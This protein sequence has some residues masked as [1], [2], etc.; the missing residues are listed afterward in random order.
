MLSAC[1]Y[2]ILQT[3][4]A[5]L[6]LR[7]D[8]VLY[9][10]G[11]E[12]FDVTTPLGAEAVQIKTS[13]SPISLGQKSIQ[14]TI[15]QFWALKSASGKRLVRMKF[16]TRAPFTVERGNPFGHNVAGLELWQRPINEEEVSKIRDFLLSQAHIESTLQ[17]W[18]QAAT[19]TQIR[20]ELLE[21][22]TWE[23][24]APDTQ[25]VERSILCKLAAFSDR[26]GS[27]GASM[28]RQ[29][30]NRLCVEVCR[31]LRN[32]APRALDSF[33]LEEIWEEETCVPIPRTALIARMSS[34]PAQGFQPME[35][36]RLLRKGIPPLPGVV[37]TRKNLVESWRG[38]LSRTG[39]LNLHGSTRTGKTTLAKLAA[40]PD[41]NSWNWW[42]A[43]GFSPEE[44]SRCLRNIVREIAETPATI[45]VV[46]D[47][48]DFSAAMI[49]GI[50]ESLAEITALVNGRRGRLIVTSQKPI[51]GRLV[52][53][54]GIEVAQVVLVPR[55]DVAEVIELAHSFD[56]PDS[57]QCSMWGTIV[58]A[59]TGGHPQLVAVRLLVLKSESWPR[60]SVDAFDLGA[61][62]VESEKADARQMLVETL[63]DPQRDL[64][65][66]LSV[67]PSS[68]RR[69]QGVELGA[70]PPPV[71]TPGTLMDSLIGP[72]IEPLHEG[73]FTL[74]P[75]LNDAARSALS[76]SDFMSLQN[77]AAEVLLTSNPCSQ[78]EFGRAFLLFWQTKNGGALTVLVQSWLDSDEP[79][80][81]AL[82]EELWWFTLIASNQG[83]RLF[84]E[85]S[86]LS[87]ILR[88]LQFRVA[89]R[90]SPE[91][92]AAIVAAWRWELDN[93]D[94]AEPIL[95]RVMFAG[96]LLPYHQVRLPATTVIH[97]IEDV[98]KA[99]KAFPDMPFPSA[100]PRDGNPEI[101]YLPEWDDVVATFSFLSS[102]RCDSIDY[103]EEFLIALDQADNEFR[104]SILKGFACSGIEL[105]MALDR[106]WLGEADREHPDWNRCLRVYELALDLGRKWGFQTLSTSA[107]R[108]SAVVL[109]EYLLDHQRA[110]EVLDRMSSP[111]DL[112]N[113]CVHDRRACIYFSE[114]NYSS[115]EGEWRLAL[116]AWPKPRAPFD[117]GSAYAAR[118][119]GVAAARQCRW[120]E[121][122]GWFRESIERL[123]T[124]KQTAYIAGAMADAG[125]CQWKAGDKKKALSSLIDAWLLVDTLATG[126]EDLRAFI[127]RKTVGHVIAWIH[128]TE[129]GSGV[130][131]L[132]EPITGTC[133][134]LEMPE[135]AR[136]LPETESANVWLFLM[137]LERELDA[138]N[139]AAELGSNVVSESKNP[140]TVAIAA[141][142]GMTKVLASGHVSALPVEVI[143]MSRAIQ[144]SALAFP[145]RPEAK[146]L[147]IVPEEFN[148]EDLL[149]GKPLFIVGLIG[150]NAQ[151]ADWR[152]T[153]A[154]W[155]T[156][157]P[158][159]A[160]GGWLEWFD[161]IERTLGGRLNESAALTRKADTGLEISLVAAWH[162]LI[163]TGVTA[164]NVFA[165]HARIIGQLRTLY[166]LPA[167]QAAFC[168]QVVI[169]WERV[170]LCPA[171]LLQPRFSVPAIR[172]ACA[173]RGPRL[174]KVARILVAASSAVK[175]G[176]GDEMMTSIR[177]LAASDYPY[178]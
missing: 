96:Y 11:A 70:S 98:S 30:A 64:L 92:V 134:S 115:A 178:E 54:L 13:P 165:G 56:C 119:G 122:A 29:V 67:F 100:I 38:I 137:R 158:S 106:V 17:R 171:L 45:D 159:N 60:M 94:Y 50:E 114:E 84:E 89:M 10:E 163:S 44:K 148:A 57:A 78:V 5:W 166:W 150:A 173:V 152:Q 74:S 77:K 62:A 151:G 139:R 88:C 169:A 121:A 83:A 32:P 142:E 136:E 126:R 123:P 76:S 154:D 43:G 144:T 16:L 170:L 127:T 145:E 59:S 7:N 63:T 61:R 40:L 120:L 31:C 18:L 97:L 112:E 69:D 135:K 99:V 176:V 68:F 51:P 174:G 157:L 109:D 138:G 87:L 143:K 2:Q 153:L 35:A 81:A 175:T 177:Q 19:P 147:R 107:M 1:E 162:L 90:T 125:Y 49:P 14:T 133:S 128:G 41:A 6:D 37:A 4:S 86:S 168:N 129:T 130:G 71:K 167:V 48:L 110:H 34:P 101:G 28:K 161:I 65:L 27:V 117:T 42:S 164:E 20:T 140:S 46:L 21:G 124:E 141:M 22:I 116:D 73:Y 58:H 95:L 85:N 111:G 75:L 3:V 149:V 39:L 82:A 156:S 102:M 108:G 79:L 8:S 12:D 47:D 105:Q 160:T 52:H 172:Q 93:G 104:G 24:R 113:H 132:N 155:R 36:V 15:N 103:L 25:S 146:A 66:R 33:R 131:D 26:H 55:L 118:S 9:V 23:T 80:A 91:R 72:W 53:G